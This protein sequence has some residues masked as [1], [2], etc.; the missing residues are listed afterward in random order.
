VTDAT[1]TRRPLRRD[2]WLWGLVAVLVAALP[3]LVHQGREQ[4]FHLDEFDFIVDRRLRAP[5]TL[6]APWYGHWVTLPAVAYR[7]LLSTFGLRTYLPYQALAIAGHFAVV[8][9]AWAT[10]RRLGTRGWIATA[11]MIPL[12]VLGSGRPNILF[13]FQITL[14]AALALGL[15][16]LLL[17][18]HHGPWNRRDTTGLACGLVAL[19]CSGVAVSTTIG[20]GAAVLV[21]RGW[22]TAL[23]H[24]APLAA[25]YAA[26]WLLAPDGHADPEPTFSTDV[27]RF[28]LDMAENAVRGVGGSSLVGVAFA[29]LAL[30][31]T[32]TTVQGSRR[33]RDRLAVLIGLATVAGTFALS[34]GITRAVLHGPEG[35]LE[36]RY[37]HVL[38]A[39]ALPLAAVGIDRLAQ[40]SLLW[41]VP[42]LA[43]LA[44]GIPSNV[45]A[46]AE[47]V[48]PN[49]LAA[50]VR[51][52]QLAAADGDR[53]LH[54]LIRVPVSLLQDA[55]RNPSAWDDVEI[56]PGAQL[57][58]DLLLALG[59]RARDG[60]TDGCEVVAE[61]SFRLTP[62]EPVDFVGNINVSAIDDG[63]DVRPVPYAETDG[64]TLVPSGSL[65]VTIEAL[66]PGSGVLDC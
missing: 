5:S 60:G 49:S 55:A 10:A 45:R 32:V 30:L 44:V 23:A 43:V 36:Q 4:S 39:L 14:T 1:A 13:G 46:L 47:G 48:P 33:D 62:G 57:Q 40:I 58:A 28:A 17:A 61:R 53:V 12:V 2:P 50:Y 29:A 35:A 25:A 3:L 65:D 24:T 59:Q 18:T 51:S 20:V 19:M 7:L 26:W 66:S 63:I 64:G 16:Q 34:S 54:P 8:L 21:L 52:E 31:G 6:F 42:G 38:V 9:V 11:T 56:P 41:T 22:R 27:I 15:T 37:V